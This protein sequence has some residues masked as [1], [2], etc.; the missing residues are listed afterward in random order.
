MDLH[1]RKMAI[2]TN[3]KY[4]HS[5]LNY[6]VIIMV[7]KFLTF[8]TQKFPKKHRIL[9]ALNANPKETT[10]AKRLLFAQDTL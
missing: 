1:D 8:L 4:A 2:N 6:Y 9:E 7:Q 5:S 10:T 3:L